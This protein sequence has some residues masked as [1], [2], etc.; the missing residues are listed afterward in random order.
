VR[1]VAD[2]AL[3]S[4]FLHYHRLVAK[5]F[6]YL[7]R[8]THDFIVARLDFSLVG[9]ERA[10]NLL[11][12]SVGDFCSRPLLSLR[13]A[14]HDTAREHKTRTECAR[15]VACQLFS[16]FSHKSE[17]FCGSFCPWNETCSF[18]DGNCPPLFTF[19]QAFPVCP[20]KIRLGKIW[21]AELVKR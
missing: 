13:T 18:G 6:R 12:I 8:V 4:H 7:Q 17:E 19:L 16:L 5:L 15:C 10:A 20:C 11:E 9:A 14:C 21:Y 1:A 2:C 3:I